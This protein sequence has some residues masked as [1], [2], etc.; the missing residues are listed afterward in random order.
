MNY[1][2]FNQNQ[3]QGFSNYQPFQYF[4]QSQGNV[5][6]INSAS[7]IANIP[8]GAGVSAAICLRE[9]LM[10][11]KTMQNGTPMLVAYK[12]SPLEGGANQPQNENIEG[13]LDQ[14]ILTALNS[15]DERL[16][17][18]EGLTNDKKGGTSEW[19]L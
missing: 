1:T 14:K 4:P 17:K 10:F 16:K 15:L 13:A 2:P 19:P 11:L 7:E 6:T 3:N 9:N 18:L 12:L 8:V 5:Y